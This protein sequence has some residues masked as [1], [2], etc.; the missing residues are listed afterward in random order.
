[1]EIIS[2]Y[3]IKV[4]IIQTIM[5]GIY[6]LFNRRNTNHQFNR[7][8][9]LATLILPLIIPF[10]EIPI[11]G[12]NSQIIP[13]IVVEPL[14][15]PEISTPSVTHFSPESNNNPANLWVPVSIAIYVLAVLFFAVKLLLS[16]IQLKRLSKMS[17]MTGLSPRGYYL[18]NI[19]SDVLS[20]SFLKKIFL[21]T[22]FP[23]SSSEKMKVI[24]HEEFH[25][26]Q[27]H[28]CDIILAEWV[29]AFFWFSPAVYLIQKHLRQIHE[30]Q[31]DAHVCRS[32]DQHEYACLLQS[33]RWK[34]FSLAL[35]NPLSG[36]SIN[37]RIKMMKNAAQKP[38]IFRTAITVLSAFLLFFIISCEEN[39]EPPQMNEVDHQFG[40]T[41]E[42]VELEI[43]RTLTRN[44]NAPKEILDIYKKSQQ[45]NPQYKYQLH[46]VPIHEGQLDFLTE[47][48]I[49]DRWEKARP[50]ID[51][52]IEYLRFLD[53][54]EFDQIFTEKSVY[55]GMVAIA[56]A[57]A[58]I[59]K[60]DRIK[61]A[62]YNHK[63]SSDNKIHNDYDTP[64]FFRGG[65]KAFKDFIRKNLDYPII[66][67]E[68]GVEDIVVMSLVINKMGHYAYLNVEEL[69]KTK[70]EKISFE[71]QKAAFALMKKTEGKWLPAEKDGKY[72]LSRMTVPVEFKLE[73]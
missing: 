44:K 46:I 56:S 21:S 3:I 31:A 4:I 26:S 32:Y 61:A 24:A 55:E 11:A 14:V 41:N 43:E 9:L 42:D 39:F 57:Y 48:K 17:S 73:D 71:L 68:Q 19:S 69:P 67:R 45:N 35:G 66:A 60:V 54:Q 22:R 30:Y 64:A 72:V 58:V 62:E 29:G 34:T 12:N 10:I 28:S 50:V 20:F 51:M 7:F 63:M 59:T 5:F 8:F 2:N 53:R 18:Y 37:K 25:I 33:H 47:G 38:A 13:G 6:W 1:M 40:Y 23:L 36:C 49:R 27:R 65:D 16:F 15:L 70:D 52:K